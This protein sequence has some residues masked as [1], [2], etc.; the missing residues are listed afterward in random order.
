MIKSD[1][2]FN[3]VKSRQILLDQKAIL[4]SLEDLLNIDYIKEDKIHDTPIIT[5]NWT[6][7]RDIGKF[8]FK[9]LYRLESICVS[10]V[11]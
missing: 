8:M 1:N 11:G 3:S 4:N 6:R 5:V 2:N 7:I 9:R 10:E